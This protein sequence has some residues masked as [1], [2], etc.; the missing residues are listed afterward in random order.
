MET[1]RIEHVFME[2]VLPQLQRKHGVH[3]VEKCKAIFV[4]IAQASAGNHPQGL[5]ESALPQYLRP[6][7]AYMDRLLKETDAVVVKKRPGDGWYYVDPI[8]NKVYF[9]NERW[10]VIQLYFDR[11]RKHI[12]EETGPRGE[13]AKAFNCS[14]DQVDA[15]I[16]NIIN[17]RD[18]QLF[19][20]CV[21]ILIGRY[22]LRMRKYGYLNWRPQAQ[23]LQISEYHRRL[24]EE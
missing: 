17:N 22:D 2:N 16:S 8:N 5:R 9:A 4:K 3:N 23:Y 6:G 14:V 15:L 10:A 24:M 20:R 7:H 1:L 19:N 18:I 11:L 21:E 13:L 12:S